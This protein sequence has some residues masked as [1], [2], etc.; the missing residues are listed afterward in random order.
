MT[1]RTTLPIRLSTPR[2]GMLWLL[3]GCSLFVAGGV[4]ALPSASVEGVAAIAFFGLG[5]LVAVVHL[6]PGSSYLEL[7]QSGFTVCN[8]FRKTRYRWI[9]VAEFRPVFTDQPKPLVGLRLVPGF[10]MSTAFRKFATQLT[11]VEGALPGTY[12][13]SA[14]E[15]AALLDKV[16]AE[17]VRDPQTL[18]RL[19]DR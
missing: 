18:A 15:L 13:L 14:T 17:Q 7:E 5:A 4:F 1:P 8:L 2:K 3:V 12:G 9:D 6:F 10:P 16:R 11:G 19:S